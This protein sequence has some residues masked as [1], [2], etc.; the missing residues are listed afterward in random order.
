MG[1]GRAPAERFEQLVAAVT[2][3]DTVLSR[4]QGKVLAEATWELAYMAFPVDFL[5]AHVD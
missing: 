2:N 1:L 4:E 5:E 3:V